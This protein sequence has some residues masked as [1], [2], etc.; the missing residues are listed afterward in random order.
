MNLKNG[1][2]KLLSFLFVAVL[3]FTGAP[4]SG[5]SLSLA[6]DSSA[7]YSFRDGA[8]NDSSAETALFENLSPQSTAD[9]AANVY[10]LGEETYSFKNFVDSDSSTGHCFGMSMT[11]SG[12]FLKKLDASKIGS[13]NGNI[14]KL[15][16]TKTVTEPICRYQKLQGSKAAAAI[17]AGGSAYKRGKSNISSDWKSVINYVKSHKYDNKGN[18]QLSVRIDGKGGHSM[19]FLRYAVV[20]GQERI[21]AYDNNFPD[22]E[23]YFYQNPNGSVYQ[24]PK[25]S[26]G[27]DAI[28]CITLRSVTKYFETVGNI[29]NSSN[30]AS[31][32]NYISHTVVAEKGTIEVSGAAEYLIDSEVEGTDFVVFEIPEEVSLVTITPLVDGADFEYLDNDYGFEKADGET[33]GILNVSVSS[34]KNDSVFKIVKD[35]HKYETVITEPTCTADGLK[36]IKCSVCGEVKSSEVIAATGHTDEN[37]DGK[38]DV[39]GEITDSVKNCSCACHKKGIVHFLFK[40]ILVFRKMIGK[41]KTCKCGI[42]HY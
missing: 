31:V 17:V 9:N 13:K 11:S 19:N 33:T 29:L 35:E 32:E 36:E 40:V 30:E 22:V 27:I 6:A 1:S 8:Q 25:S 21:Y 37:R 14:Y 26:F 16:K 34:E 3:L 28:G 7:E 10:N 20:G 41:G 39:C 42:Y 15:K 4:I 2:K 12:Y 23:T 18:L 5:F 24:A 38:C